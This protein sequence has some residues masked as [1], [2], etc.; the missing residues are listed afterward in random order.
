MGWG[1]GGAVPVGL[2]QGSDGACPP[3]LSSE[4][5]LNEEGLGTLRS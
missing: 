3:R 4:L 2:E 5:T 1:G